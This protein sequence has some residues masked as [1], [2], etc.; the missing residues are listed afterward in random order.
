MPVVSHDFTQ[1]FN[2]M[3]QQPATMRL[4]SQC[5]NEENCMATLVDGLY[6]RY[7]TEFLALLASGAT[8]GA[9]MHAINRDADEHY[10]VIFTGDAVNPIEIFDL[11][12]H[13]KTVK[14]GTLDDA[15]VFTANSTV[16]KYLALQGTPK[17]DLR[18][19]TIADYTMVCN[20]TITTA[21]AQTE[22]L[23]SQQNVAIVY[24]KDSVILTSYNVTVNG[25]SAGWT[26]GSAGQASS[27]QIAKHLREELIAHFTT[28]FTCTQLNSILIIRFNN[29]Q[30]FTFSVNDTYG[31]DA[32]VGIKGNTTAY[33]KLPPS[34]EAATDLRVKILQTEQGESIGYWVKWDVGNPTDNTATGGNWIETRGWGLHNQFD[35]STMPHRLVR[36]NDGS[37]VF[38]PCI[39]D[40][41]NVG[42]EDTCPTPSFIGNPINNVFFYRNRLGFLSKD[43]VVMSKAGY[44]FTF[45]CETAMAVL[46]ADP[47]DLISNSS[48]VTWFREAIPFFK[49]LLLRSDLQQFILTTGDALLTPTSAVISPTTRFETV[50]NGISAS[51]GSNAY[52]SCPNGDFL[53][54]REY[55]IQPLSQV[56]DAADV[57]IHLPYYIPVGDSVMMSCPSRD[58]LFCYVPTDPYHIYV[59]KYFWAGEQKVQ[60]AW[61]K[62]T[63]GN[64]ILG[65]AVFETT[66]Y[67][68]FQK[69]NGPTLEKINLFQVVS[70]TLP[71]KI[72]LDGQVQL[73]GTYNS[74]L[75]L[76]TWTLPYSTSLMDYQVVDLATGLRLENATKV[77]GTSLVCP[78]SHTA[79]CIVGKTYT[80]T[81]QPS[82]W[83]LQDLWKKTTITSGILKVRRVSV[84][85][86]A[87]G[88]FEVHI[89]APGRPTIVTPWTSVTPDVSLLGQAQVT[90]GKRPF[91]AMGKNTSL[92]IE[93]I[94][95]SHLP[96]S[97]QSLGYEGYY[98]NRTQRV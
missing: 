34:C 90:S 19:S 9:F 42:D 20:S 53:S 62:W 35:A 78:G 67:L 33:T 98:T 65:I 40:I 11:Q 57:T 97:I 64:P 74:S 66:L 25:F 49:S 37:F 14:Y 2:G 54:V 69:A 26:T 83:Y 48:Q 52:F 32:S 22:V 93:V 3:S 59:Y 43:S 76:T 75:D 70:G 23:E 12:G 91:L 36:M 8:T 94:S 41:R 60:S 95:S 29:N 17:T 47:I 1:L 71:F 38:A 63:F 10:V 88:Y 21:M 86:T 82:T 6:R 51:V 46:E 39:W 81:F 5:E 27:T 18:A 73:T 31:D 87:S 92:K 84:G 96:F 45:W 50:P 68:L 77:S 44:Y 24:I 89:T 85:Y 58:I 55:F 28:N 7:P 61:Y 15:L 72:R 4:E 30:D 79:P 16:K 13:K 80:S 56:D